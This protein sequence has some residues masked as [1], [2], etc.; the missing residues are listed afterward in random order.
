MPLP[1]VPLALGGSALGIGAGL[2]GIKALYDYENKPE[3]RPQFDPEIDFFNRP[4]LGPGRPELGPGIELLNAHLEDLRQERQQRIRS[5]LS[6]A[7]GPDWVDKVAQARASDRYQNWLRNSQGFELGGNTYRWVEEG[8]DEYNK[9]NLIKG[10]SNRDIA[11]M[12]AQSM[13]KDPSEALQG[14]WEN[15]LNERQRLRQG[16][17]YI[18]VRVP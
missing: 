13:E 18:P 5:E 9:N 6:T 7:L 14:S 11:R 1:V 2:L 8:S 12:Y 16:K 4:H 15:L 10:K 3:R 17:R